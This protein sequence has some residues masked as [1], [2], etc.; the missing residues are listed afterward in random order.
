MDR[1]YREYLYYSEHARLYLSQPKPKS[2][3][4]ALTE[5]PA[6][7]SSSKKLPEVSKDDPPKETIKKFEPRSPSVELIPAPPLEDSIVEQ[8]DEEE[9]EDVEI[10]YEKNE[11][12][13]VMD[14]WIKTISNPDQNPW[15]EKDQRSSGLTLKTNDNLDPFHNFDWNRSTSHKGRLMKLVLGSYN[16]QARLHGKVE[17]VFSSG[18]EMSGTFYQGRRQGR[19]VVKSEGKGIRYQDDIDHDQIDDFP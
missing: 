4:T 10:F 2:W 12:V 6:L 19:C 1:S 7:Q 16:R 11:I 9:D 5:H 15:S 14:K 3:L 13:D 17:L 18:E 8:I